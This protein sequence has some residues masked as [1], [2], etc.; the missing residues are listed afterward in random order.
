MTQPEP[1]PGDVPVRPGDVLAGKY[2]VDR[3][4]GIG[5]MGVV[6]AATHVH[7]Q[8]RVAL[9]F[10]LPAGLERPTFVERFSREARAAVR[11][12]SDHVARVL[13]VG[14]LDS[15]SPYI[16]MEY[17][18]GSDIGTVLE[19]RGAMSIPEA[20]D[21]VMQACDA[22]AEAHS[23]GIVH[24]DL[25]PRNLF[26]TE[27]NDGRAL[28]KVL[29]F[30]I[31]KH[32]TGDDL[33]L[34]RTTEIMG[35]PSYMSPEQFRSAKLVDERSDIWALGAIL[36]E[37][38]TGQVPFVADSVTALT[39]M[40]LMEAPRPLTSLRGDV[41]PQLVR[42]VEQCLAKDPSL[43]FQSVSALAW[44]LEPFAPADT[45]ELA[46]RI[47]RIGTGSRGTGAGAGKVPAEARTPMGGT[48]GNWS[49][50]TDPNRSSR[51]KV[52]LV[53]VALGMVSLAAVAV[54]VFFMHPKA[55][56]TPE[57]GRAS[58]TATVLA[59]PVVLAPEVLPAVALV[60]EGDA[61][62]T[63]SVVAPPAPSRS[64]SAGGSPAPRPA[65][66]KPEAQSPVARPAA[67]EEPPKY[68]TSW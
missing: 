67:S 61:A 39:A 27:R 51:G 14:K 54:A 65:R 45:R 12:R 10:M 7:L 33:S 53:V 59:A 50:G 31:S 13:D 30:G 60:P 47:G 62:A 1:A 4:L 37:L 64:A 57:A 17:L 58:A 66:A 15:G 63:T 3:I 41:P 2:R 18:D 40:V 28:V 68:R 8:Q 21:C 35:S 25:K 11:L 20:V 46:T 56:V 43:R 44:A 6:V 32:T 5:G 38:L 16:V 42:V 9:K 49:Q 22:V 26:L 55:N 52:V 48:A 34:T 24:R 19:T 23:L 36:Y 29:D